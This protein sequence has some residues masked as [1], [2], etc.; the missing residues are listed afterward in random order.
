MKIAMILSLIVAL[1]LAGTTWYYHGS[2]GTMTAERDS[3]LNVRD[4]QA[5]RI[6][7]LEREK[8]DISGRLEEQIARLSKE[9]EQELDRL[10]STYDRS[11]SPNLRT[12][13]LSR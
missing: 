13:S 2:T 10:R 11:P 8:A 7:N 4:E 3:L 1:G 6:A 12:G 5:V 9:K